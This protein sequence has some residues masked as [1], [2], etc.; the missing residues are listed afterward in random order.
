MVSVMADPTTVV[1]VPPTVIILNVLTGFSIENSGP[2]KPC[3]LWVISPKLKSSSA[4]AN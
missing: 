4:P 1:P 3:E 2:R